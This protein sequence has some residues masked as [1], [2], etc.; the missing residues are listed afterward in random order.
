MRYE[1]IGNIEDFSQVENQCPIC[2]YFMQVPGGGNKYFCGRCCATY[3][4][5]VGDDLMVY[6]ERE[7]VE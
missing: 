3:W 4:V 1:R 2:G 7:V 5:T 6:W